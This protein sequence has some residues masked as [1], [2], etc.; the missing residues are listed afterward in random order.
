MSDVVENAP[1]VVSPKTTL[2]ASEVKTQVQ[3]IQKVMSEVMKDGVHY[4]KVQGCG[5]RKVLLKAGADKIA[6]TFRLA[7]SY[8]VIKIDLENGHREYE[9][10]CIITNAVSGVFLGQG[11]GSCSTM[12]KKYRWRKDVKGDKIENPDIADVYNTVLK[13]AKKRAGVDAIL[14]V[15]AAS[16][17]FD[18]DL[19]DMDPEDISEERPPVKKPERTAP[20]PTNAQSGKTQFISE[21]QQRRLFAIS[22]AAGVT[23]DIL[24][25]YLLVEYSISS[26]SE[27]PWKL[28]DKICNWVQ[29]GND[30]GAQG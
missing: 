27:I 11:V 17:V 10:R 4:G 6:M 3:L 28:Y 20:A 14:T 2:S 5:D 1:I 16:D 13:M 29:G 9:V 30:A 7:P 19:D 18:Q 8:D 23:E 24:K 12:E 25:D 15:T 21:A 22:K 26:T